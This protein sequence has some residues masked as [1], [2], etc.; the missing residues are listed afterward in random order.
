MK[1]K[2]K[3]PALARGLD[4]IEFLS[5]SEPLTL[6]RLSEKLSIPKASLLRLLETLELKGYVEKNP[7][8]KEYMAK[9]I[10]IPTF[11]EKNLR[12][13]INKLLN[14]L[15]EKTLRTVEFYIPDKNGLKIAFRKECEIKNITVKAKIGF[16]RSLDS[17]FEAV[18]RIAHAFA[19]SLK[20]QYYDKMWIYNSGQIKKI[21][22][23][24]YEEFVK[25][26]KK[27][28]IAIDFEFNSNGVR[29]TAAPIFEDKNLIGIIALAE[30]FY[31]NCDE[32]TKKNAKI[33]K[34]TCE[35]FSK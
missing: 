21:N 7:K 8:N 24:D 35:L 27:E 2:Y 11:I 9:T 6:E 4:L 23:E 26:T 1:Q 17:E 28:R 13:K 15:S 10:I 16:K 20:T 30:N 5:E 19:D 31:P 25:T 33:L 32:D 12:E 14:D 3:A 29:R 34:N 22:K 18:T